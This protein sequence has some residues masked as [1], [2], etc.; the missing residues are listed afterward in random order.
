M[1]PDYL[2]DWIASQEGEEEEEKKITQ[3]PERFLPQHSSLSKVLLVSTDNSGNNTA[4]PVP[5]CYIPPLA[6]R[7]R[8]N[9]LPTQRR[10]NL[11]PLVFGTNTVNSS[12]Y[13][14]CKKRVD[15]SIEATI[16][17][18]LDCKLPSRSH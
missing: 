18:L 15:L 5:P 8:C 7:S 12:Q 17:R 3:L 13:T 4:A 14:Y 6:T 2:T 9:L 10:T 1:A 11:R 16:C